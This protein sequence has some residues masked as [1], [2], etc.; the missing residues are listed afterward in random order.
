MSCLFWLDAIVLVIKHFIQ[1]Y[2]ELLVYSMLEVRH[3]DC[4]RVKNDSITTRNGDVEEL[5]ELD[6]LLVGRLYLLLEQ[7]EDKLVHF[8]YHLVDWRLCKML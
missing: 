5:E 6:D 4:L 1:L 3:L 8:A 2:H 7:N